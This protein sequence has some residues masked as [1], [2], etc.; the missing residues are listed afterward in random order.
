VARLASDGL[1]VTGVW[2]DI[3]TLRRFAAA[4]DV[5]PDPVPLCSKAK[6]AALGLALSLCECQPNGMGP[7]GGETVAA[8]IGGRPESVLYVGTT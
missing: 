2:S 8:V 6:G 5:A 4:G 7:P 1:S 3:S